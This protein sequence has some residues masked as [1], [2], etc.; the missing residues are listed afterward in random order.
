MATLLIKGRLLAFTTEDWNAL[1]SVANLPFANSE[2]SLANHSVAWGISPAKL[3]AF[4]FCISA[5]HLGTLL[6]NL[7]HSCA[8]HPIKTVPLTSAMISVECP[9]CGEPFDDASYDVV[10]VLREP[11]TL[12]MS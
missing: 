6:I 12:E 9:E 8:P 3:M 11:I 4:L 5:D 10:C 7:Y 1:R 2:I